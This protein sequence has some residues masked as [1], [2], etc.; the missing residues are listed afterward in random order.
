MY[1]YNGENRNEAAAIALLHD[2][3]MQNRTRKYRGH[4]LR[5]KMILSE[6]LR[7]GLSDEALM[8]VQYHRAH[9]VPRSQAEV[10]IR[11]T[12]LWRCLSESDHFDAD[13]D[14]TDVYKH[15]VDESF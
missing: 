5:S 9:K 15:Y 3:A 12:L 2:I 4:G 8:C 10:D 13:H 7:L 1:V 6:R 11:R 14:I